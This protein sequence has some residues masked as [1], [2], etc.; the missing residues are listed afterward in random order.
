MSDLEQLLAEWHEKRFGRSVNLPATIRKLGEEFGELAEAMAIG[1]ETE[2][3]N[4]AAD[5]ALVLCH[6]VRGI[7]DGRETLESAMR[8]KFDVVLSRGF[9]VGTAGTFNRGR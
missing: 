5:M 2:I 4:E 6:I 8:E 1:G 3:V 9:P 7:T